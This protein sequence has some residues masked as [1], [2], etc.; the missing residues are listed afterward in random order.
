MARRNANRPRN[1]ILTGFMGSG[2]TTVGRELARRLGWRF[3]DL[4]HEIERRAR[5][6][7]AGLFKRR[8]EPAFRELE[9]SAIRG[10]YRRC[11]CVVAVGG[12]APVFPRN[13]RWLMRAGLVVW[14]RVPVSELV[15]RLARGG[16]RP[17]LAAARGSSPALAR[18]VRAL[19]RR[20]AP[21]YS[22]AALTVS[23]LGS[24]ER[25][26]ALIGRRVGGQAGTR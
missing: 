13:R 20:R 26:A 14:L 8:G 18:L 9:H 3:V 24:P 2:K 1:I 11:R 7:V 22:R 4:D 15:R 25:V 17:L 5:M 10:L 23:G 12:G 6:S 16:R 21:A 19:L